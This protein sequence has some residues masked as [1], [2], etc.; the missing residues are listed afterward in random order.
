MLALIQR[1]SALRRIVLFQLLG[2]LQYGA[3]S[4]LFNLYLLALGHAE[5]LV[6]IVAGVMTL[7]LS[8]SALATGRLARRWGGRRVMAGGLLLASA[9]AVAQS[10]ATTAVP[11]VLFAALNGCGFAMLQALQMPVLADHVAPEERPEAAA[12]VAAV[13]TLSITGGTLVGGV[14]PS[15]LGGTGL[16]M[17]ARDRMTLLLAAAVGALGVIPLL[18]LDDHGT[19]TRP[20]VGA[21]IGAGPAEGTRLRVQRLIRRYSLATALISCGAGAFLPFA[22]VY[23]ARLGASAGAI[24]GLLGATGAL[25]AVV[26]LLGPALARRVGRE[27]LAV[28]LRLA[29]VPA[30]VLLLVQPMIPLVVLTYAARQIGGGMTWP[31]EASILNDRVDARTRAGAFGLRTAAWNLGWA[32]SSTVSGL[33]IV[34]GGYH[35]PLLI[36]IASTLLGAVT[37]SLVLR[38]AGEVVAP[39]APPTSSE[40]SRERA[41]A[42]HSR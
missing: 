4:L 17:V 3:F 21:R 40:H 24:G 11:I 31:I 25:G 9:A 41:T 2:G 15:L 29:P 42:R 12:L 38:P 35:Y 28:M 1:N 6:G 39:A 36:L 32:L 5:D 8:F 23:L 30:A 7:A 10:L 27:R 19:V 33:L 22:N 14:L 26:G 20:G 18:G 37:L 16:S 13:A 34:R